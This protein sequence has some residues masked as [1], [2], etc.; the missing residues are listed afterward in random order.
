MTLQQITPLD[1][2]KITMTDK[3]RNFLL[4]AAMLL[5][6]VMTAGAQ[7]FYVI[8]AGNNFLAHNET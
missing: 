4:L 2:N 6:G 3:I 8:K 5:A 7:D 1:M